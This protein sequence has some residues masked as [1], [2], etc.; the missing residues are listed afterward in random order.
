MPI[1]PVPSK[2]SVPGSGVTTIVSLL[3]NQPVR[4]S[5]ITPATVLPPVVTPETNRL[6]P[7]SSVAVPLLNVPVNRSVLDPFQTFTVPPAILKQPV[8]QEVVPSV[9]EI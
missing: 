9:S 4:P 3:P 1:R 7:L 5:L 8:P 6:F 2:P